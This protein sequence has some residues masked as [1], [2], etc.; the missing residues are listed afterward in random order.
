MIIIDG[1]RQGQN[2]ANRIP[3]K[4]EFRLV[5]RCSE[6]QLT[7]VEKDEA[8]CQLLERR[9]HVPIYQGG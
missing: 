6:H 1:G 3:A 8:T 2:I 5:F 4:D 7:F 9:Y